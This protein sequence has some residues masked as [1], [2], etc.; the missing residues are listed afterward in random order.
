VA[1]RVTNDVFGEEIL[2]GL[3]YDNDGDPDLF[4]GDL[5][6]DVS[7]SP[8]RG[9]AGSGHVF[10]SA[11]SLKNQTFN[12]NNLP[13]GVVMT[14][15]LG[16]GAGNILADTALDGDFDGDAIADLALSSP[17]ADPFGRGDAGTLHVFHGQNGMW[18]ALIDLKPGSL[19]AASAIRISE[20]YGAKGNATGDSGDTLCY[21]AAAGDVDDDGRR[22]VITNEMLGNGVSPTAKDVG[23]LIVVSG[24]LLDST[25]GSTLRGS[26]RHGTSMLAVPGVRV[27]LI[28]TPARNT[29]T[30]GAG[31]YGFPELGGGNVQVLPSRSGAPN[32]AVD[33]ADATLALK[34]LVGTAALDAT[35][36]V[37]CDVTA[38][39]SLTALDA[40]RIRQLHAGT[41]AR[42]ASADACQS[43]WLFWP[44]ASALANQTTTSPSLSAGSCTRG[45]ITFSPLAPPVDNRDFNAL[46]IGDCDASWAP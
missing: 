39:G 30:N 41:L 44:S 37:A 10:Y 38:N 24:A 43:D 16:G 17:H 5:T 35:R 25:A 34:A 20:I 22:D 21:S 18:P 46:A 32:G 28:A 42:F 36:T 26:I 19:P 2:G 23:N 29:Q 40:A 6:A 13:A 11:A 4:V 12:L 9:T 15:F 1:G 14:T 31:R 33:D 27:D 45:R 7:D 3:D 8:T